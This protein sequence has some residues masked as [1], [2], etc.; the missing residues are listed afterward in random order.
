MK[1][2]IVSENQIPNRNVREGHHLHQCRITASSSAIWLE[3]CSEVR[4]FCVNPNDCLFYDEATS[5]GIPYMG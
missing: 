4:L 3:L 5:L 2:T 1:Q